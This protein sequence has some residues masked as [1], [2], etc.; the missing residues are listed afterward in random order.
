MRTLYRNLIKN[1]QIIEDTLPQHNQ[2]GTYS[3]S[4]L[5]SIRAY[6][7]L[8]HAEFEYF[9]EECATKKINSVMR[10]FNRNSMPHMLL[11]SLTFAFIK[12]DEDVLEAKKNSNLNGLLRIMRTKYQKNVLD[13]NHGIKESNLI[14]IYSPLG[15]DI[16]SVLDGD[17]IAELSVLG[18]KRGD[19]AHK[20]LHLNS[21][22]DTKIAVKRTHKIAR[23]L[24][25]FYL[26]I[27]KV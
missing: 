27:E 14:D 19:F 3:P 23:G 11:L 20:A 2:F 13:S 6:Y 10:E 1:L 25:N 16:H 21:I 22:E 9:F 18:A 24:R 8:C 12:S 15:I 7:V 17:V 4:E 5:V 26:N